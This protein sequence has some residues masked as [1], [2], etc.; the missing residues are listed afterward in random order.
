MKKIFSENLNDRM[1]ELGIDKTSLAEKTGIS[2]ANVALYSNG[3]Y[4]PFVENFKTILEVLN[5]SADFLFGF[6]DNPEPKHF[7]NTNNFY[8]KYLKLLKDNKISHYK[9]CHALQ[10]SRHINQKWRNGAFPRL[11]TIVKIAEYF[12]ESIDYLIS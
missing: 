10:I 9:L 3:I 2:Y 1:A 6:T 8:H 5:C 7:E 4:L 11:E 12:G